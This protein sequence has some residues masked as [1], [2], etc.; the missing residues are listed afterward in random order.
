MEKKILSLSQSL[1]KTYAD[2]TLGLE[3]GIRFEALYIKKTHSFPPSDIQAAGNWFE[4]VATG[5]TLRDGEIPV[6]QLKATAKP[7]PEDIE[8]LKKDN[9]DLSKTDL[10][11]LISSSKKELAAKKW[12]GYCSLSGQ[13][14][15]CV[16][17][18]ILKEANELGAMYERLLK[19]ANILKKSFAHYGVEILETGK[20]IELYKDDYRRKGIIDVWC[21][22]HKMPVF[23]EPGKFLE[24]FEA[25]IDIKSTG[26]LNNR[27]EDY[28]W[29]LFTLQYKRKLIAQPV[30]YKSIL[31]EKN[32][33]N[34]IPF[35]FF[36]HSSANEIES[37]IIE[38]RVKDEVLED[39]TK[40]VDTIAKE[41]EVETGFYTPYPSPKKCFD[42]PVEC[43]HF[44]DIPSP[45]LVRIDEFSLF[46]SLAPKQ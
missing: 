21:R 46:R 7:L 25:I 12:E 22:I 35:Y 2:Y 6:P 10:K 28:G 24:P 16:P 26:L 33:H 11:A 17:D 8:Q 15:D 20:T 42:C 19:Q 27:W 30:D 32:E 1:L 9:A 18:H 37:R 38:I 36:V 4:Y 14:Y 39:H 43:K 5:A 3:C 44:T 41:I 13:S 23:D 29:D 45:N 34:N 40:N 31:R